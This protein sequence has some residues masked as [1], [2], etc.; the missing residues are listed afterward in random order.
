MIPGGVTEDK[1]IDGVILRE[2]GWS[3]RAEDSG[4]PTNFGITLETFRRWRGDSALGAHDLRNMAQAEARHIYAH[5]Y[6]RKPGFD[7]IPDDH[8]R[9][10]VI[11]FGVLH[12]QDTAARALQ[13]ALGVNQ[14]AVIGPK[15]LAAIEALG[16]V[17]AGNRLML[18]RIRLQCRIVQRRP[19]DLA[20]LNGWIGRAM[21]FYVEV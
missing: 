18:A 21:E 6:I 5:E 7:A 16:A 3:D 13:K 9:A 8:L 17:R 4:G 2:G 12:G 1:I 14:D 11:D 15:T 19:K 20:N 10:H